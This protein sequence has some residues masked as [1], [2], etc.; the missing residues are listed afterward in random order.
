MNQTSRVTYLFT[1]EP[2]FPVI[3]ENVCFVKIQ[4][5]P[6]WVA[7]DTNIVLTISDMRSIA[8]SEAI[9]PPLQINL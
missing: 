3:Q 6:S 1:P 2:H 4:N 5:A 9:A 7:N 8:K